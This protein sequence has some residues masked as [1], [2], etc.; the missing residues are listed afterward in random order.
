[1]DKKINPKREGLIALSRAVAPLVKMEQYPS[2]NE[3]VIAC[4]ESDEHRY[5]KTLKQWNKEGF[6]VIK[7]S[8]AFTVWA[9]PKTKHKK[10]NG[11]VTSEEDYKFFPI[12]FLFSNAQVQPFNTKNNDT[13]TN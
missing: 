10:D 3:A 9:R 4:Y 11:I 5:F 2:I 13:A 6:R 1:M 8:E 7:G 12:C